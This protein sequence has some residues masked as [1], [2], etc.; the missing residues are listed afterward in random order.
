[1]AQDLLRWLDANPG[2]EI[3][4]LLVDRCQETVRE[5]S[6]VA[7][8]LERRQAQQ[9]ESSLPKSDDAPALSEDRV[10]SESVH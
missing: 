8:C 5:W 2:A 10:E 4:D 1:M 6:K 9:S 3:S 7:D